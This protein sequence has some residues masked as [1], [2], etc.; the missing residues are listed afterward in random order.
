MVV[1]WLHLDKRVVQQRPEMG[2]VRLQ[3]STFQPEAIYFWLIAA[4][5]PVFF[6]GA[7]ARMSQQYGEYLPDVI[8]SRCTPA[9]YNRRPRRR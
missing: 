5:S 1:F 9:V 8:L 7:S 3:F 4:G 2:A 6:I